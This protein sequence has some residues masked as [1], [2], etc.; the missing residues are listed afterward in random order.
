MKHADENLENVAEGGLWQD[1]EPKRFELRS[2]KGLGLLIAAIVTVV[3]LV[4]LIVYLVRA[5]A[6]DGPDSVA[7]TVPVALSEVAPPENS[8][9]GV[10]LTLG[11]G[12]AEGS[13]WHQAA[14]GAVVAQHRLELG[15]NEI[16]L[17][18]EN[19]VGTASGSADAVQQLVDEGVSGIIYASSGEHMAEGLAVAEDAGVPVVLPYDTVPEEA[20]NVWSLAPEAEASA[21]TLAAEVARFER[22]LHINAGRDLPEE[23]AVSDEATYTA[24]TDADAFAED[25]AL[26]TGADPFANGAYTGGGEDEQGPAPV[27][28]NPADVVVISGS[29]AQQANVVFALQTGNVSVPIILTQ[30]AV[31]PNF[32]QTLLELGGT[33]S[34]NLRTVGAAWDDGIALGTSGQSRAMS[35]F[36]SA[37]RQLAETESTENLTGDAPFTE[38]AAVVEVRG[39]DAVLAFTEGLEQAGTTEPVEV[40]EAMGELQLAA[41][42]GIAGPGLDFSAPHALHEEPTVLHASSQQLGLRPTNG[43]YSDALV[44]ITQP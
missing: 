10:V 25:I 28:E 38:A 8:T 19:D 14:Q 29:P 36:L 44:W 1:E 20:T 11:S 41:G 24:E 12:S 3:A 6:D 13:Q 21:A 7:V 34:S 37:T 32:D 43:E 2:K 40:A 27:V 35:A 15:G 23:V 4:L 39:H 9:I 17:R 30:E 16:T 5:Q 31:S 26:R 18:A 33:V 22:P 42:D